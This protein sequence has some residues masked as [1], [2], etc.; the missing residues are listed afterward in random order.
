MPQ[1][2]PAPPVNPFKAPSASNYHPLDQLSPKEI[3][4]SIQIV[5]SWCSNKFHDSTDFPNIIIHYT[6][7]QDP[8]KSQVTKRKSQF[9]T[10]SVQVLAWKKGQPPL[11]RQS[12]VVFSHRNATTQRLQRYEM[13]ISITHHSVLSVQASND[14]QPPITIADIINGNEVIFADPRFQTAMAKRGYT[15]TQIAGGLNNFICGP[16]AA[17][18][19]KD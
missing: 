13:V 10:S 6:F 12:M 19:R 18:N 17:G 16:F 5:K 4:S 2:T 11:D 15:P 8:P 9:D 14:G 3:N 7:L 1:P